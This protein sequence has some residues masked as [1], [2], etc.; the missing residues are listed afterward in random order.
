MLSQSCIA[1]CASHI[2]HHPVFFQPPV[3]T[4]L[5]NYYLPTCSG[6][7]GKACRAIGL[8][9]ACCAS[10]CQVDSPTVRFMCDDVTGP[11]LTPAF[12]EVEDTTTTT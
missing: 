3:T 7:N 2:V 1:S 10:P 5:P 8:S 12:Q 9:S 4:Y 11:Y 6:V